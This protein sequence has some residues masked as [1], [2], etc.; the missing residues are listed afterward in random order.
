MN[1]RSVF[2][3]P[4]FITVLELKTCLENFG[5]LPSGYHFDLMDGQ[6]VPATRM[7]INAINEIRS[8]TNL[9]FWIHL[10]AKN[11]ENLIDKLELNPY[12]I[13]SIHAEVFEKTS[14]VVELVKKIKQK[15]LRP[16]LALNPETTI[17]STQE[18]LAL[19]D[20][21]LIMSVTPGASGQ[22][23]KQ[24]TQ[25]KLKSIINYLATQT[26]TDH[27]YTIAVDGGV[28]IENIELLALNGVETVAV[29]SAVFD[30]Q[31][32]KKALKVLTN[33]FC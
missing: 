7:P 31:N 14:S 8:L 1:R 21:L 23:F 32:P 29:T 5:T 24:S 18:V 15:N 12:D 19:F 33:A 11:P 22:P 2:L 20:H 6:F 16:S 30:Q 10:M 13:I 28:G 4:P 25:T 26:K 17:E 3:A 27:Q 9:P